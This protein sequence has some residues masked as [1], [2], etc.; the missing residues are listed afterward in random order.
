[1]LSMYVRREFPSLGL[2]RSY[3]NTALIGL[4]P[5]I[6]REEG[7][8]ALIEYVSDPA[9]G[10]LG[11]E[12]KYEMVRERFARYVGIEDPRSTIVGM[13]GTTSCIERLVLSALS[14]I[15]REYG[16][17]GVIGVTLQEYPGVV[18]ALRSLCSSLP[19]V[20]GRL[21]YLGREGDYRWE[22]NAAAFLDEGEGR[23]L[24]ASSI[25][26]TTGYYGDF[27]RLKPGE[28]RFVIVDGA[29]HFGHLPLSPH[30]KRMDAVCGTPRKWLL[31][32]TVGLGVAYVSERFVRTVTP[33][34]YSRFSVEGSLSYRDSYYGS[35]G[36]RR[37]AGIFHPTSGIGVLDLDL[38]EIVL[39]FLTGA[40]SIIA[41]QD[42]VQ[43]LRRILVDLLEERG[44]TD[45]LSV[46]GFD[47]KS[48]IVLVQTG[49]PPGREAEIV[50][51]LQARGVSVSYREQAGIHGIRVSVHLYN[52]ESDIQV[53]VDELSRLVGRVG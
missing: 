25:Q 17:P 53:F 21:V 15:Y 23:I 5:R 32:P 49:L 9:R 29:H 26:W 13:H 3:L 40:A 39:R 33:Y 27:R 19:T 31:T 4:P 51:S 42:H 8:R 22:D 2:Y 1:L 34:A 46:E 14:Y 38:F 18:L 48:G 12:L 30:V 35:P 24:I 11:V 6:A 41:V 50:R 10:I 37:D 45:A 43:G 52:N 16:R 44:F 7:V 36:L 47:R 20:C 28:G